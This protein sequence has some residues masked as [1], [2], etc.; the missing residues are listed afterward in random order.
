LH[1]D[2][3]MRQAAYV[4]TIQHLIFDFKIPLILL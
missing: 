3:I 4:P 1:L 2:L